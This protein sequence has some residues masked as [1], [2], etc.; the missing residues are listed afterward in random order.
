[1]DENKD[2]LIYNLIFSNT[3]HFNIDIANYINDIYQYESFISEIKKILKKSKVKI[4]SSNVI[5]DSKTVTW[6]LKVIK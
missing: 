2:N 6:E 5:V 1:M 3:E 4:V